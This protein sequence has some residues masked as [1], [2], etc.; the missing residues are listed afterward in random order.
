MHA[1]MPG[2]AV[3]NYG[4]PTDVWVQLS[5]S[6]TN[7][8]HIDFDL[9]WF[10]KTSTR[11]A[12]S[13]MFEFLPQPRPG[14]SWSMNKLGSWVS[15]LDVVWGGAQLQ[16]GVWD[17]VRYEGLSS[18]PSFTASSIDV[19]LVSPYTTTTAPTPFV[20]VADH[21]S[22]FPFRFPFFVSFFFFCTQLIIHASYPS[23][24]LFFS[25]YIYIY[26]PHSVGP[27]QCTAARA[28]LRLWL[29]SV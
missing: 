15:P 20:S 27:L 18:Q 14:Y 16:H 28:S 5:L 17:G 10:N 29:Q 21:F 3:T 23:F 26:N 7:P 11:L 8:G 22:F 24:L 19:P 4:A 12:E 25:S 6:A 1:T 9:Q 13:F 2:D